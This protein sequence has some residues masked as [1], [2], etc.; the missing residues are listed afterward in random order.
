M[1]NELDA[2]VQAHLEGGLN[3]KKVAIREGIYESSVRR[4]MERD[5]PPK[6]PSNFTDLKNVKTSKTSIRKPRDYPVLGERFQQQ[7]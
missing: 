7:N 1:I 3:A 5:G 6:I 4:D 2:K